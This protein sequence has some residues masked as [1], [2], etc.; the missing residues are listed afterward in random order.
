M[1]KIGKR[2]YPAVTYLDTGKWFTGY[3]G[4]I[5]HPK[6]IEY[7]THI[8]KE[9]CLRYSSYLRGMSAANIILEDEDGFNYLMSM[10]G[11]NLLMSLVTHSKASL[12][13]AELVGYNMDLESSLCGNGVWFTGTFCQTKQG[14]NYFIEPLQLK[15]YK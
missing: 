6:H 13:E 12:R 7:D 3:V 1:A 5:E 15:R 9:L 10:S 14:Q 4:D 8:E 2:N 11:F